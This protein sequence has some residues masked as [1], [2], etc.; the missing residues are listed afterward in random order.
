MFDGHVP[1]NILE[2][3]QIHQQLT[4]QNQ[5]LED[6]DGNSSNNSGD[7][8]SDEGKPHPQQRKHGT[9]CEK[10]GHPP[11]QPGNSHKGDGPSDPGCQPAQPGGDGGG[12][13]REPPHRGSHGGEGDPPDPN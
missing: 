3:Q 12:D 1:I 5:P 9:H 10:S 2:K 11:Y 13:D 6:P 7:N 4:S 8:K